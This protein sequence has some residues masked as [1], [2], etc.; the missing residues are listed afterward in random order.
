MICVKKFSIRMICC[1]I[2]RSVQMCIEIRSGSEIDRYSCLC[3]EQDGGKF[4][5]DIFEALQM[6]QNMLFFR[7]ICLFHQTMKM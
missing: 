4:I 7:E 2:K 3:N 6:K 5:D 1:Q